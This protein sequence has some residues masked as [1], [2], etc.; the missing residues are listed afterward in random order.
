MDS[1]LYPLISGLATLALL[2]KLPAL[3]RD[4]RSPTRRALIAM[5]ACAAWA[6][7][8]NT[9]VIYLVLDELFSVPNIARLLSHAGVI[10]FAASVQLLLLYWS[11]LQPSRWR[12]YLR[13]GS[14][15]LAVAAMAVL[16]A[17]APVD[18]TLTAGEFTVVYGDAPYMGLYMLVYL[19]YFMIALVDIMRLSWPYAKL[20][21]RRFI[22]LGLRLI[23]VGSG[24]G[25]AYCVEKAIYIAARRAGRELLPPVVQESFGP[26]TISAASVLML[27][28]FTI[29]SWGPKI[30]MG[31]TWARRYLSYW[32]LRRLWQM[33]CAAT[34][35]IVFEPSKIRHDLASLR[36]LEYRLVRRVVEIRD[37]WLALRDYMNADVAQAGRRIAKEAGLSDLDLAAAV[38]AALLTDATR[39]KASGAR[40]PDRRYVAASSGVD[41]ATLWA[42]DTYAGDCD[43]DVETAE[44]L[45]LTQQ[46]DSLVT[47]RILAESYPAESYPVGTPTVSAAVSEGIRIHRTG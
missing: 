9:P 19:G 43:I 37:G 15:A 29:P 28:G 40:P 5:L 39:A 27:I 12:A 33:M 16:F 36:D 45:R 35:E 10:G 26:L 42:Q 32:R 18:R 46:L 17:L 2:Y 34:P 4:P 3:V 21:R 23:T 38:D 47:H 44:L 8:A 11:V 6:P 1:V 24:F 22:R 25:A 30:A 20:T 31:R 13:L 7:A 14:V 41:P